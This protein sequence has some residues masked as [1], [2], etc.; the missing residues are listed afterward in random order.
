MFRCKFSCSRRLNAP[1]VCVCVIRDPELFHFIV[2]DPC[3]AS[4]QPR[5]KREGK[6]RERDGGRELGKK[7]VRRGR[8]DGEGGLNKPTGELKRGEKA[9]RQEFQTSRGQRNER[10]GGNGR[11]A[12]LL[13]FNPP[14]GVSMVR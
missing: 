4:S 6:K 7:E 13:F 11:R 14:F 12:F 10:R 3:C 9:M 8:N 5:R 1:R 2:W